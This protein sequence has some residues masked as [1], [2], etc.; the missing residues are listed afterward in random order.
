MRGHVSV[1]TTALTTQSLIN[2]STTI[3]QGKTWSHS[4]LFYFIPCIQSMIKIS[5]LCLRNIPRIQPFLMI[6]NAPTLVQATTMSPQITP[7][8]S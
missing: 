7:E 6:S 4:E 5:H 2:P 1:R 8:A 3:T